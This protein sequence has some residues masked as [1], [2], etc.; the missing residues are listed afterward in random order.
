MSSEERRAVNVTQLLIAWSEGRSDA[1]EELLPL[2]YEELRRLASSY[3]RHEALDTPFS[4]RRS[5][6]K[7]ISASSTNGGCDGG[8]ARISTAWRRN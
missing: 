4:R 8:I 1:L 3:L 6:T 7:P 2:V 5:C